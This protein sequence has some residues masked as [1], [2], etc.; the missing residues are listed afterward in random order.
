MAQDPTDP[1]D[2]RIGRTPDSVY[3]GGVRELLRA[4]VEIDRVLR[5]RF[6]KRVAVLFAELVGPANGA[7]PSSAEQ[8]DL[9]ARHQ[10]L[11]LPLVQHL[12]GKVVKALGDA[13]MAFFDRTQDA[14]DCA[15]QMQLR[16]ADHRSNL[17][18]DQPSLR[19]RI[20]I[21]FGTALVEAGD[22]YGDSVHLAARI[23]T[24]AQPDQILVSQAVRDEAQGPG[25]LTVGFQPAA[26][27][28]TQ[29]Q[30]E[31]LPLF[32][33][34]WRDITR[35]HVAV[36]K[37]VV[38]PRYRIEELLGTGGMASVWKARDER[39][40][41]DVAVKVLHRHLDL[42]PTARERFRREAR[43]AASLVQENIVQV[44]DY[45]GE[46]SPE[47]FIVMELVEGRTLRRFL[48]NKGALPDLVVAAIG[49]EIARGLAYAHSKGV[50]HRDVKPDNVLLNKEGA[51]KLGDFGIA[52][53]NEAARLTVSG[54]A[55]GS[56]AYMAPEQLE[57][58]PPAPT[59]DV[60]GLG[61]T[62]YEM[63]TGRSPFEGQS[64]ATVLRQVAECKFEHPQK[65]APVGAA[66]CTIILK[67]MAADPK[68]R[69]ADAHAVAGELQQL[70][71]AKGVGDPR[72]A[73]ARFLSIDDPLQLASAAAG[74]DVSETSM[75]P[76][77]PGLVARMRAQASHR[78]NLIFGGSGLA[79]V[80]V[81]GLGYAIVTSHPRS[82]ELPDI[83][84]VPT[85][86]PTAPTA[87]T[88]P[89]AAASTAPSAPSAPTM[90]SAQSPTAPS[91]PTAPTS[92]SAPTAP[93]SSAQASLPGSKPTQDKEK[94]SKNSHPEKTEKNKH[95]DSSAVAMNGAAKQS[96]VGGV[97][98]S[99][100]TTPPVPQPDGYLAVG[101][102]PWGD[103][104]LVDEKLLGPGRTTPLKVQLSAG[105][106]KLR[107]THPR[108]HEFNATV[109]VPSGQTVLVRV[110]MSSGTMK[111]NP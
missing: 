17:G 27:V 33:A 32:E 20:G 94:K 81:V 30:G 18:P 49:H 35:R 16:L 10:E 50:V 19:L 57:G 2:E 76:S 80:S 40:G 7:P 110:D 91:A 13:L 108:F 71:E 86:A 77:D 97:K 111:L 68:E 48:T 5:E 44:F 41:R 25:A 15:I 60:F 104:V 53:V 29:P 98:L 95:G 21:H 58:A 107:V 84:P 8:K 78:R 3:G 23:Q 12:G 100:S 106:H 103:Q 105:K 96:T 99:E 1:I 70:L 65:Y 101:V 102:F 85:L 83:T 92:P 87:P 37:P 43:T 73:L 14:L 39:L 89:S 66:L 62:L 75:H 67:A 31:P 72:V 82:T 93:T 11:L 63:S 69:F 51:V 34:C 4:K 38:D 55:V 45:A 90:A 36:N 24:Q 28:L 79:F 47:A 26:A 9:F 88:A 52:G 56:P 64:P 74:F 109:D 42:T 46:S 59:A 6:E 61:V 22:V 54:A